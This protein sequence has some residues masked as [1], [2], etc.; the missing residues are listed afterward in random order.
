MRA[1]SLS[2]TAWPCGPMA[3]SDGWQGLLLLMRA[4]QP[5]SGRRSRDPGTGRRRAPCRPGT[6]LLCFRMCLRPSAYARSG[7][8]ECV[9]R[10]GEP[11]YRSSMRTVGIDLAAE[12][13]HTGVAWIDWE[14]GCATVANL[15]CGADDRVILDAISRADKAGIDCPL[16]W[17]VDFIAFIAAHQN[18]EVDSPVGE[19]GRDW[20]RRLT[21]RVTD[22][23]VREQIDLVP[24]SV[25]ADRI[26]YV[27]LRCAGL[28]EQL[29]RQGQPVDRSGSGTVVEVY[30][31]A[32]LFR[33]GLPYRRYKNSGDSEALGQI[34]SQL[35]AKAGWLDLGRYAGPCQRS[36]DATDAVIAALT[37]RAAAKH[38]TIAPSEAQLRAARTEGW[39]AIPADSS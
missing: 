4:I 13:K 22:R 5:R 1:K 8:C 9:F 11:P 17:P 28:L 29:A 14:L 26:G 21:T 23:A 31:A 19:T 27:A 38:L 2:S 7:A 30:P 16:G 10:P 18:G 20:R 12:P 33:W 25:A 34:V 32:S 35:E 39:I 6:S 37:A 3:V 24:L 15:I 36:H